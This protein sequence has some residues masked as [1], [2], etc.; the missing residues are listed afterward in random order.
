M[1]MPGDGNVVIPAPTRVM[2]I[3]DLVGEW[4]HKEGASLYDPN[5]FSEKWTITAEGHITS[6]FAGLQNGMKVSEEDKGTVA[7]SGGALSVRMTNPKS[8][9]LRGWLELPD[10]TIMKLTGPWYEDPIPNSVFTN[11]LEAWN[12]DETWVRRKVSDPSG[13]TDSV[14]AIPPS[15]LAP[16]N[17]PEIPTPT[18]ANQIRL[19]DEVNITPVP[20]AGQLDESFGS[21]GRVFT[22]FGD[23]IARAAALTLQPDGKVLV[24]GTAAAPDA[25]DDSDFALARYNSD[26]SLDRDF[27]ED[28]LV[29]IDIDDCDNSAHSIAL[30]ADGKIVVAGGYLDKATATMDFAIVRLHPTGERDDSFNGSGI[31]LTDFLGDD[32]AYA[33]AVQ[34]D[35]KIVA[36]GF[37]TEPATGEPGPPVEHFAIARYLASG[38]LD[39]DF[40]YG[41]VVITSFP[42]DLARARALCIQPT[43]EIVA[44]GVVRTGVDAT[45]DFAAVRYLPDGSLDESF[46]SKGCVLIDL[47]D[48]ND[49]AHSISLQPDGRIILGGEA[50]DV[51]NDELHFLL[52][53]LTKEG[54]P[55]PT[56][57]NSGALRLGLLQG[58]C[59][60]VSAQSEGKIVAVGYA[61][62]EASRGPVEQ[63]AI[64][65]LED[66]GSLDEGFG[67]EGLAIID[68]GGE[69]DR[70]T[71]VAVEES[72]AILVAG[73]SALKETSEFVLVKLRGRSP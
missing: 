53:R 65:Q 8:Y 73:F 67:E 27:G 10:A 62:L 12:L 18:D 52:V 49:T 21:T 2:T 55:D 32:M 61:T 35:G 24:A 13:E 9:A 20:F 42:G 44:A 23:W 7:L 19:S 3:A 31:V 51:A 45:Y 71:A 70:G 6:G 5:V 28:G 22:R 14:R 30:Q 60:G 33:V 58:A 38:S 16:A 34:G 39:P 25:S 59:Y 4:R 72:G 15:S 43:G 50:E 17:P 41:G 1:V 68:M 66:N 54:A 47:L 69:S 26:G 56:F 48:T 37:T 64:V 40:G 63:L 36:A 29:L 11:P 57:N 46:G